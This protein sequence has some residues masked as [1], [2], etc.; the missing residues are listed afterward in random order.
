MAEDPPDDVPVTAHG[1]TVC[2]STGEERT[3][4]LILRAWM[5]DDADPPLRVRITRT[6]RDRVAEPV[7]SASV[8]IEGTCM[9]VRAWLEHL[10]DERE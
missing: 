3:A 4:V 10:L 8:T 1:H 5:E 9:V 6:G 7:S 2:M